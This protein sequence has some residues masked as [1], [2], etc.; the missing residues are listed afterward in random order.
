MTEVSD[1]Q[2]FGRFFRLVSALTAQEINH[3]E[4]GR[5]LGLSPHTS[6]KWMSILQST[7]QWYDIPAF[8]GNAIKRISGRPKGFIADTGIACVAQAISTP[9][10]IG[11]HPLWGALFESAVAAELRKHC[12]FLS[13][14]PNIYHWRTHAGA[15]VDFLLERDG[16]FYPLEV[17][18]TSKPSRRD[19]TGIRAFRETYPRLKIETGIVLSPVETI[20]Q[21]SELDFAVPWDIH[22]T[23]EGG[24]LGVSDPTN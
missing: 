16:A 22:G 4:I 21:L 6:R 17:K 5:E 18:A 7:Y 10:A 13:P 12:T 3:S 19:T 20:I 2:L 1:L 11:G 8:S 15:E 9:N 23:S 24:D 14:R